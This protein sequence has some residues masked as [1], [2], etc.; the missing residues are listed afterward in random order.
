MKKRDG[1]QPGR[2]LRYAKGS[3]RGLLHHP[4]GHYPKLCQVKFV[5][6][7][8]ILKRETGGL[9]R[10]VQGNGGG[11]GKLAR[12]RDWIAARIAAKPDLTLDDPVL[13]IADEQKMTVHRVSTWR[14]LRNLGLTHKKN[15]QAIGQKRPEVRQARHIWITRRQP[16]TA[17]LLPRIGFIDEISL[18]T[19]MT[20][21]TG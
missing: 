14:T 11:H 15:L 12:L 13:K 17:N 16:F 2:A 21:T 8:V 1:C 20:K 6:E 9:E 4:L 5:N 10:R 7:I 18:K 19:N 3:A